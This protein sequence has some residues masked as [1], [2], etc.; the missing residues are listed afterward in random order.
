MGSETPSTVDLRPPESWRTEIEAR[1]SSSI[2]G[3][4]CC[5]FLAPLHTIGSRCNVVGGGVGG[6]FLVEL[7]MKN[8]S[9]SKDIV[10]S[11]IFQV[12]V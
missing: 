10:R 4:V 9:D 2:F 6:G 12:D 5:C 7:F 8:M 3:Q 11:C 1:N